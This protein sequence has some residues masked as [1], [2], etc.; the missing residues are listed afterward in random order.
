MSTFAFFFLLAPLT[1]AA[2]TPVRVSLSP[3]YNRAPV[4][5]TYVSFNLDWHLDAEEWPAWKGCS[6]MNMSLTEPNL[7]FLAKSL[8]P[9]VL[10]V[11][12]SEGDEVVYETPGVPCP[13]N[14]TFCLT[15]AR[16]A[17]INAFAAS[18]GNRVAF[19]LNA[20]AGRQNR[21]CKECPW[22]PT[23]ARA[24]L[25]ASRASG[26]TPYALEFGN[27]LAPIVSVDQYV[28]DVLALRAIVDSIWTD[29][30]ERPLLVANDANPDPSYLESLLTAAG[31]AL[32]VATWHMYIAYGLDPKLMS[33]AWDPAEMQKINSTAAGILGAISQ[34]RFKG[35]V[36]VGESA[37]AWH[38]GQRGVTDTFLSAPWWMSA[39]GQLSP[40]HSGFCRQTLIGGK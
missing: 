11:G 23:N 19:G 18:T 40:T 22:D 4:P 24:F 15:Q 39:L 12:G 30:A 8:S 14:T 16:W 20:M 38:S 31:S 27:E 7:V 33:L 17:E 36:W 13:P 26:I 35:Q 5:S 9:A 1:A 37:F 34:A 10:R 3:A 21:S 29:P 25:A 28:R 32:D 6:V 2:P